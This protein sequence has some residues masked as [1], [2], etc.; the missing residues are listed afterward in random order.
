M[1]K[2]VE[3][4]PKL[5]KIGQ[6]FFEG[7]IRP[8]LGA[9]RAEV[10][11]GP[12]Y[13]VDVAIVRL[14]QGQ[15]LA[16]TSDPLSLI[17]ALGLE[18]SAWLSVH[19]LASDLVTSGIAPAYAVL[20][21]NLPPHISAEEFERYWKAMH[22][23]FERLGV[24]V[25]GGHTG[26][27]VGCDYTIIG[28]ATL[29]GVGPEDQYICAATAKPGDRVIITKGAA[30]A[31]TGLLAR[32]FPNILKEQ[33]GAK[34]L[35]KAQAFFPQFST[36]EDA[37][38]TV[39]VGVRDAGVTALHDATE[40]GVLGALWE[41]AEASGCGIRVEKRQIP[42]AK[43]ATKICEFFNIDPYIAL[44]EGTLVIAARSTKVEEIL[45]A[46]KG[47]DIEAAEVGE[48]TPRNQGRWVI[49]E[50]ERKPLGPV[51]VDPYW[52]AFWKAME[53]GWS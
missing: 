41:L 16:A 4:F 5:G 53:R 14:G 44:S 27:F 39:S 3:G 47:K 48:L 1:T 9:P 24:A 7:V 19:L 22:Q 49:E 10:L 28:G 18:D 12:Q 36:V 6:A 38:T 17:P 15:V 42:V 50:G 45:A 37:L 52:Q 30:I 35:A 33:F 11:V 8:Q 40:G 34:F 43:E 26:K 32:T 25:I 23:E 29:L 20:D 21:F 13:G 31:T 46:L 2:S 51:R